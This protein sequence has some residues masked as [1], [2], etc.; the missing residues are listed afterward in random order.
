MF[1]Q[2]GKAMKKTVFTF[3]FAVAATLS[4]E[5]SA[6]NLSRNPW[7]QT[8]VTQ[9]ESSAVRSVTAANQNTQQPVVYVRVD[10]GSQPIQAFYEGGDQNI[11]N[12]AM[13]EFTGRLTTW[14]DNHGQIP[15]APEVNMHNILSI[16]QHL[17]RMG[18]KIPDSLEARIKAAP[19]STKRKVMSALSQV[20]R[21]ND[22]PSRMANFA[23]DSLES[24]TGLSVDNLLG[25][26]L[27]LI[28]SK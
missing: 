11:W 28:S 4:A 19:A 23:M 2:V 10:Q 15:N 20:R 25:N 21:S 18:Y 17:R 3:I 7:A 13:P 8:V 22:I 24:E 27:D 12:T 1:Q 14:G 9:E 6:G 16:T 5:C 26:S